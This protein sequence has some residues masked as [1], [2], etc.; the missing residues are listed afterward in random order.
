MTDLSNVA[1]SV[2]ITQQSTTSSPNQINYGGVLTTIGG[3][4]TQSYQP[5]VGNYISSFDG[6]SRYPYK[7]LELF[8]MDG[9]KLVKE[10]SFDGVF[11]LREFNENDEIHTKI[12]FKNGNELDVKCSASTLMSM[13]GVDYERFAKH[14]V[15]NMLMEGE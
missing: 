8:L 1:N 5:K 11:E 9:T 12:I 2:G 3:G 15:D 10:M 7:V 14:C 13:F 4:I 6:Y